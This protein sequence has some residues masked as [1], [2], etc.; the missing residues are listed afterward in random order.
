MNKAMLPETLDSVQAVIVVLLLAPPILVALLHSIMYFKGTVAK[1]SLADSIADRLSESMVSVIVPIKNEPEDLVLEMVNHLAQLKGEL[2]AKHEVLIVSD[3]LPDDVK[4]TKAKA[5]T[6]AKAAGL[7]LKFL[8]RTEGKK[9]R[10]AALNWVARKAEGEILIILDVDT[11]PSPNYLKKLVRCVESGYAAC[12]GRWEGYW[13]YKTKLSYALAKSM[14]YI[15]DT[16]Y[17]GRSAMGLFI[18]PLGSGTAFSKRALQV[19]GMWDEDV[20]QD[21]MRIGT[22]LMSKGFQVGYVDDT[23]LKVLVP[24]TFKAFRLQQARWSYG[25][26]ETIRKSLSNIIKAPI[27]FIVKIESLLFLMQ[28]LP[29]GVLALSAILVP[30]LSVVLNKDVMFMPL[31]VGV[32]FVCAMGIYAYSFY[33]SLRETG[34]SRRVAIRVL[35]SSTAFTIAISPVILVYS[36]IG[37]IKRAH[38]YKVTPKGS[39]ERAMKG[40]FLPEIMFLLYLIIACIANVLLSKYFTAMWLTLFILPTAYAIINAEKKPSY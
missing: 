25:A 32:F 3:D 19:V 4:E 26:A 24:S 8:I 6:I 20:I 35:G 31:F 9:G 7:N 37:I 16:L 36:I 33:R 11:R 39:L 18:F 30:A 17:R 28:Y 14:K 38:H 34:L 12:V 1:S 27:R 23:T 13:L 5:E 40:K 21:D 22:K 10:A 15:V 29:A 2:G